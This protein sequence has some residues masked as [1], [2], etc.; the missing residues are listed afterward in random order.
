[1]EMPQ[2]QARRR[3]A[4]DDFRF[5]R[6][7]TCAAADAMVMKNIKPSAGTKLHPLICTWIR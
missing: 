7:I 3:V 5:G 6:S 4:D 2:Q 1:M